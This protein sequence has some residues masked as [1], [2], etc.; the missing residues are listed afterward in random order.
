MINASMQ[1]AYTN[2]AQTYISV[3]DVD[4]PVAMQRLAVCIKR[5]E[6]Q[7]MSKKRL[8]LNQDKTPINWIGT[9]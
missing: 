4:A 8:K 6:Q 7:L 1:T 2:D 9:R 3:P 5:V